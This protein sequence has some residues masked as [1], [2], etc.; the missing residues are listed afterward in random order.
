A[1]GQYRINDAIGQGKMTG[2]MKS[3]NYNLSIGLITVLLPQS[4]TPTT[5]VF[6]PQITTMSRSI[7]IHT[8]RM[9]LSLVETTSVLI[10]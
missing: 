3:S 9:M 10:M 4:G 8:R 7:Q 1:S 5:P 6:L 2:D